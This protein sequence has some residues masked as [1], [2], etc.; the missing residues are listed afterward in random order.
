MQPTATMARVGSVSNFA[1]VPPSPQPKVL[2]RRL[3]GV[4]MTLEHI[5][6]T[7]S[8]EGIDSKLGA[9][10]LIGTTGGNLAGLCG[11]LNPSKAPQGTAPQLVEELHSQHNGDQKL[12]KKLEM[13]ATKFS[14]KASGEIDSALQGFT[15]PVTESK[16]RWTTLTEQVKAKAEKLDRKAQEAAANPEPDEAVVQAIGFRINS[17]VDANLLKAKLKEFNEEVDA[18]AK[19]CETLKKTWNESHLVF[20]N[21][22]ALDKKLEIRAATL[23]KISELKATQETCA[24]TMAGVSV[25]LEKVTPSTLHAGFEQRA[26]KTWDL[27][28]HFTAV[29]TFKDICEKLPEIG[30]TLDTLSDQQALRDNVA[31]AL[32]DT[33]T[34]IQRLQQL[35][36]DPA[37]VQ[38]DFAQPLKAHCEKFIKELTLQ[39]EEIEKT[40]NDFM[41]QV[42]DMH[43]RYSLFKKAEKYVPL[44]VQYYLEADQIRQDFRAVK[45][46]R[47]LNDRKAHEDA[48]KGTGE[49]TIGLRTRYEKE[50]CEKV[51]AKE[52]V[53]EGKD[54]GPALTLLY[55]ECLK[56][57]FSA[58]DIQTGKEPAVEADAEQVGLVWSN[59]ENK[60]T[61]LGRLNKL[62]MQYV[63][64]YEAHNEEVRKAYEEIL[65]TMFNKVAHELNRMR[66]ALN[67]EDSSHDQ[68]ILRAYE[69]ENPIAKAVTNG[70][71]AIT[72]GI[73]AAASG[74]VALLRREEPVPAIVREKDLVP[75]ES[76]FSAGSKLS[77]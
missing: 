21:M 34:E 27:K 44:V 60:Q 23:P 9:F 43:H 45:T 41:L 29:E 52:V 14:T 38:A 17:L 68:N 66:N 19:R 10:K 6:T 77:V 56:A 31:K 12:S 76:P 4:V 11:R 32:K 67:S 7:S 47:K 64:E 53:E 75:V 51:K 26:K 30:G 65:P 55:H 33:D 50:L 59:E 58:E 20:E 18:R 42:I 70:V 63:A 16:D 3:N 40:W 24:N 5:R 28:P 37:L 57:L 72:N 39:K 8:R 71:S 35:A 25:S 74:A 69:R 1:D 15:S 61:I 54:T 13:I 36:V 62:K 46:D 48:F 22:V 2:A 73:G 49:S